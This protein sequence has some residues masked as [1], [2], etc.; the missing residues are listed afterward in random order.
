VRKK[1]AYNVK[2]P[3]L[4][5]RAI[6]EREANE[7]AAA[8]GEPL[9]FPNMWDFLDPTKL[10]PGEHTVEEVHQRYLEFRKICAPRPRKKYIVS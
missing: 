9:P 4:E 3:D 10:S 7:R 2:P 1:K 6:A 8:A 5:A